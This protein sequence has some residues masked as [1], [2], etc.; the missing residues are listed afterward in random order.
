MESGQPGAHPSSRRFGCSL[1]RCRVHA[2]VQYRN[3]HL[4]RRSLGV[5]RFVRCVLDAEG[6]KAGVGQ[7]KRQPLAGVR[8]APQRILRRRM[9]LGD[10]PPL[11][12]P[13]ERPR[14][15]GPLDS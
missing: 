14:Q 6:A 13:G 2:L 12:Q 3:R 8:A 11:Q 4:G 1:V 15:R 7:D 9:L 5:A 10:E